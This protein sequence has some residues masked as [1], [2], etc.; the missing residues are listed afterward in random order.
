MTKASVKFQVSCEVGQYYNAI[1]NFSM[2]GLQKGRKI[3][4]T[5][6]KV[7]QFMPDTFCGA[8]LPWRVPWP[9]K[10]YSGTLQLYY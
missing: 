6:V 1:K 4:F 10:G 3:E 7:L 5:I 2:C 8:A 9:K